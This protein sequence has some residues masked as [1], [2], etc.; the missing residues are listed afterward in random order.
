MTIHNQYPGLELVSP[1]YFSSGTIYHTPL[2]QKTDTDN[3]IEAR[4][5][6]G[7]K[8]EDF[9]C[10]VLYKLQR[11]RTIR[12]DNY[13]SNGITSINDTATNVYLLVVWNAK[14]NLYE[15][16]FMHLI[17]CSDDFTW[18]EDKL[19]A[20]YC[21]YNHQVNWDYESNI[22]TWLM[23]DNTVLKTRLD[24][25]Y[26]SDYKLDIVISEGTA[27]YDMKEPI[28]IDAKRL[29]YNY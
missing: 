20:L 16:S 25:T 27:K 7:S 8:Q 5:G 11:R 9:R 22:V 14:D 15:S 29:V 2:S 17:E 26:G 13:P 4:F 28:Y 10:A 19:W 1:V 6:I 21:D 12:M 3:T 23:N 24:V 18:D